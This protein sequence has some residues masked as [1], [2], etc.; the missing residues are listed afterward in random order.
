MILSKML[1]KEDDMIQN[2]ILSKKSDII[3]DE[4]KS[5]NIKTDESKKEE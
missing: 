5:E 4:D 2:L 3:T 1:I